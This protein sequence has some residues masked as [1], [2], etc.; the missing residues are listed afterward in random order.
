MGKLRKIVLSCITASVIG[1]AFYTC[2]QIEKSEDN[3]AKSE[4]LYEKSMIQDTRQLYEDNSTRNNQEN[5]YS[6]RN[7]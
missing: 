4:E 7:N 2:D 5:K 1:G 6:Q 3:R